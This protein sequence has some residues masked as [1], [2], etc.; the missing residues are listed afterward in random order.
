MTKAGWYRI[1]C[2][3]VAAAGC[4]AAFA[5]DRPAADGGSLRQSMQELRR[6][7]IAPPTPTTGPEE[8]QRMAEQLRSMQLRPKP[9]VSEPAPTTQMAAA[10]TQPAPSAQ[11][12]TQPAAPA[13]VPIDPNT[14][15][16][17][18]KAAGTGLADA[19]PLADRLYKDEQL[20]SAYGVYNVALNRKPEGPRKDWV[21]FQM[22]NCLRDRDP[23]A[24]VGFYR[25]V[26]AECPDSEWA[27]AAAAMERHIEWKRTSGSR[28]AV[29]AGATTAPA[30]LSAASQPGPASEGE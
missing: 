3:T 11:S 23:Q 6:A 4:A 20:A 1:A 25:R 21:L 28:T 5:Q 14:L 19:V 12:R 16:E 10:A 26:A 24:A 2:C 7:S 13:V 9:I 27:Q 8:T 15:T 17:L 18:R 22:G 29:R 30:A